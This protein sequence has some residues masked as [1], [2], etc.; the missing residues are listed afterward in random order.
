MTLSK[1]KSFREHDVLAKS[2]YGLVGA[3]T[4]RHSGDAFVLRERR[5]DKQAGYHLLLYC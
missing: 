4:N 1:H 2:H 3:A 5:G